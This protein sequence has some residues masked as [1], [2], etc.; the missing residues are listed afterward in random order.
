MSTLMQDEATSNL[1]KVSFYQCRVRIIRVSK[2]DMPNL[3]TYA[4]QTLVFQQYMVWCDFVNIYQKDAC[5]NETGVQNM[6]SILG[7]KTKHNFGEGD[8]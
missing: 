1:Q 2:V 7:S 3:I 6:I 8:I 4:N 5:M